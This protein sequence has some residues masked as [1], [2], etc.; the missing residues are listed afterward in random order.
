MGNP[1]PVSVYGATFQKLYN[2]PNV[3]TSKE[4]IAATKTNDDICDVEDLATALVRYDNGAV[5]SIE[6]SFSLNIKKDQGRIEFFGT[7]GGA[8][9]E[10]ELEMYTEI[11]GYMADV[12]LAAKTAL[13]FNGLFQNEINHYVSRVKEGSTECLSPAEDGIEIMRILTAIYES[14]ETGHEVVLN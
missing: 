2:R 4:Y 12:T 5:L 10:P 6:A 9:L 13:D 14:A 8:K 3:K 11:N 7:K 1:K